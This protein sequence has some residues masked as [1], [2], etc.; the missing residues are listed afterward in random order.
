MGFESFPGL[1]NEI[2]KPSDSEND[3]ESENKLSF[4]REELE[5][6]L[7]EKEFKPEDLIGL[8]EKDFK[9]EFEKGVGT[10]EGYT[11]K[12]HTL[13]VMG[14]FEKYFKDKELPT[15]M[16]HNLFRVIMA[17][18]DI[19]KPRAAEM[20]AKHLQHE[21]TREIIKPVLEELKFNEEEIN[22]ALGL[23]S[24]DPIG[25]SLMT[26]RNDRSVDQLKKMSQE[27][28]IPIGDFLELVKVFYQVDA[29]SYTED[30]GGKKSLDD[31]FRF[32]PENNAMDLAEHIKPYF[33]KLREDIK[34]RL[35][36]E[37]LTKRKEIL[38]DEEL[39]S[40]VNSVSKEAGF[41]EG[42]FENEENRP[43]IFYRCFRETPVVAELALKN[44][45]AL[46]PFSYS[47]PGVKGDVPLAYGADKPILTRIIDVTGEW[48]D[49]GKYFGLG[50]DQWNEAINLNP[51]IL[52]KVDDRK[53]KV[54]EIYKQ[55][56]LETSGEE[57]VRQIT[58]IVDKQNTNELKESGSLDSFIDD[59]GFW[60]EIGKRAKYL[61]GL[62]ENENIRKLEL[63]YLDYFEE[64]FRVDENS[65]KDEVV[66]KEFEISKTEVKNFL[67][68]VRSTKE[69][70]RNLTIEDKQMILSK[71][72]NVS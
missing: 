9:N 47:L 19:G 72:V 40:V 69:G 31:L 43:K 2:E 63:K 15:G 68:R 24:G 48:E 21:Y 34:I 33:E 60:K 10:R 67:E 8:F 51:V 54:T 14:Q 66:K 44:E 30:S 32:D 28:G 36:Q 16:D 70:D 45:S 56:G 41:K 18:H 39:I 20:R 38:N 58:Y 42:G 46:R 12:E 22:L 35:L 50:E 17:V 55:V 23:V 52:R 13:M 11:L 3:L 57:E 37:E 1:N 6:V 5:R 26:G 49:T 62:S 25:N 7:G 53:I 27:A 29:G 64:M 71:L 61:E 65:I 59:A 4:N